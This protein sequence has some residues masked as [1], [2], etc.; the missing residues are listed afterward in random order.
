MEPANQHPEPRDEIEEGEIGVFGAEK[1]FN[2]ELDDGECPKLYD[3]YSNQ[4]DLHHMTLSASS[5][6][7]WNIQSVSLPNFTR[8]RSENRRTKVDGRSFF[9]SLGSSGSSSDG[10][11]VYL[12]QN[13]VHG[14][15]YSKEHIR[16]DHRPIDMDGTKLVQAKFKVED[17]FDTQ[18]FD[19]RKSL[20]V[21]GS[22]GMNKGDIAKNLERKL[23]KLTWDAFPNAPT[24]SSIYKSRL[25]GDDDDEH[26]EGSSDLFEIGNILGDGEMTPYAPS[27][28]SIQW[29]VV[30]ASTAADCSFVS[31]YDDETKS[32][33][34]ISAP[35]S[36][37]TVKEA[38]RSRSG[39]ILGCRRHKA[40]MVAES[41][42]YRK[43]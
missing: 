25:L 26:S 29:S 42:A 24:I 38:Q 7:S 5:E 21:F 37:T 15:D 16:A 23:C 28:T 32:A 36:K 3:K 10:K 31:G 35:A 1:Y 6:T 22:S 18:S 8:S 27:E 34:S 39:G 12:N 13:V 14:K 2:M 30:T 33:K 40:V 19:P 9:S 41:T 43:R 17:E 11:S 20:E 4:I